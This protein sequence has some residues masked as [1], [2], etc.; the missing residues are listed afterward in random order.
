V[1]VRVGE[2]LLLVAMG[3]GAALAAVVYF[4]LFG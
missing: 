3:A 4:M 2:L 1:S